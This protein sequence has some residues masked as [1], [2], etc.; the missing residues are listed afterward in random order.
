MKET[1]SIDE[2]LL[3][4]E[5]NRGNKKIIDFGQMFERSKKIDILPKP[6]REIGRKNS[7]Q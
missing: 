3:E 5:R 4:S 7:L 6:S 1:K 2:K